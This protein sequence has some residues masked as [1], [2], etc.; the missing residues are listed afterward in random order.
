MVVEEVLLAATEQV[1]N[2]SLLFASMVN[3]AAVVVLKEER[4]VSEMIE[5]GV[6]IRDIY[7]NVSLLSVLSVRVTL[8]S[9]GCWK[10]SSRG[11]ANSSVLSLAR[12]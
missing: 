11:L 5:S 3:K 12:M 9:M 1:G 7:T 8:F 4:L 2:G 10:M 6:V